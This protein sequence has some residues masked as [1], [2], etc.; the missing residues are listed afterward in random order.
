MTVNETRTDEV[1]VRIDLFV[2]GSVDNGI[3]G[4]D[5]TVANANIDYLIAVG[6]IRISDDEIVHRHGSSW[7]RSAGS[8]EINI[9]FGDD[10]H[11]IYVHGPVFCGMAPPVIEEVAGTDALRECYPV[12]EQLRPVGKDV[13]VETVNKMKAESG[14][15]LFALRD[16][17]EAILGLAGIVVETNLYHGKHAWV[18]DLVVDGDYRGN[19]YGGQMLAWI[20]DW[21]EERD[22]SCVEL[23]SGLWRDDAHRFYENNGMER[24]C[25]TFKM[26][27]SSESLY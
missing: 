12:M 10:C 9:K 16:A 5:Y 7:C 15:R 6:E 22:C 1:T 14:Y 20:E 19:G 8:L 11:G 4:P 26:D 25:Y 24:Y 27:L 3:D 18:H 21:A 2:S 17:E 23:A 13:F